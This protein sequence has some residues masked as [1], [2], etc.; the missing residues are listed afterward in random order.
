MQLLLLPYVPETFASSL[1]TLVLAL[2]DTR[3][4]TVASAACLLA[5]H[6]HSQGCC[7]LPFSLPMADLRETMGEAELPARARS[8]RLAP[9]P[10]ARVHPE[11]PPQLEA[12]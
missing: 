12:P 4:V 10:R 6:P 2:S 3:R 8:L 7:G 5:G 9:V 1:A 11:L